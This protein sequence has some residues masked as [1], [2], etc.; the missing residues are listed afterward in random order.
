[1]ARKR[2]VCEEGELCMCGVATRGFLRVIPET[3]FKARISKLKL[4]LVGGGG[5][6]ILGNYRNWTPF[7]NSG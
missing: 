2:A 7:L 1:V 4:G 3:D 6:A 5:G